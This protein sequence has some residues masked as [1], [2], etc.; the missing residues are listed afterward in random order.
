MLHF[1]LIQNVYSF[2]VSNADTR[3]S[4]GSLSE[5][6]VDVSLAINTCSEF[7]IKKKCTGDHRVVGL[8]P[9]NVSVAS[10]YN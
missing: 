4:S 8:N 9:G 1:F 5:F 10:T 3:A 2:P 6:K 7:Y